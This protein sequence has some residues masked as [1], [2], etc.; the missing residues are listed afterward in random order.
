MLGFVWFISMFGSYI[1][2]G[3]LCPLAGYL[4]ILIVNYVGIRSF[5]LFSI[6]GYRAKK[7]ISVDDITF[8]QIGGNGI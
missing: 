6:Q 2:S 3:A 5:C 7:K 4:S 8:A 1:L